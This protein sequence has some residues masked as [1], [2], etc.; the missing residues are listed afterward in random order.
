M[1]T[2]S[3]WGEVVSEPK[4]VSLTACWRLLRCG[5]LPHCDDSG[6][7]GCRCGDTFRGSG[8]SSGNVLHKISKHTQTAMPMRVYGGQVLSRD[9]PCISGARSKVSSA[10]HSR[11]LLQDVHSHFM[12]HAISAQG[13]E[14]CWSLPTHQSAHSATSQQNGLKMR[15]RASY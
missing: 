2:G 6:L 3:K 9:M 1:G 11:H 14:L 12:A 10:E 8:C 4:P 15:S 7:R 13:F 5:N